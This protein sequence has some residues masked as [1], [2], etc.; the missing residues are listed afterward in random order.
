[1]PRLEAAAAAPRVSCSLCSPPW[2]SGG[3][4]TAPT[5]GFTI[6]AVGANPRAA[7]RRRERECGPYH[8]DHHALGGRHWRAL[9]ALR[10]PWVPSASGLPVPL[11]L[12]IVGSDWLRRASPLLCSAGHGHW[13]PCSPACCSAHLHAGGLADAKRCS[14]AAH[15]DNRAA[16]TDRA[17]RC[18]AP[19]SVTKIVALP[20]SLARPGRSGRFL[21]EGWR[22]CSPRPHSRAHAQEARDALAP[23][24]T[25]HSGQK[26]RQKRRQRIS[27]GV[28][29]A[30]VGAAPRDRPRIHHR[31]RG[32][33][34]PDAV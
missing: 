25:R 15:A 20:R 11:S 12:G 2:R 18:G 6:R 28:L 24:S 14:D 13:A 16:G 5:T 32:L 9:P 1:M 31:Q 33:L 27:T 17:L 7:R 30:I 3:C 19:H 22:D 23:P 8:G 10:R 26:R 4:W 34:L 29:I 21:R